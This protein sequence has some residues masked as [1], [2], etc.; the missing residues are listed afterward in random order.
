MLPEDVREWIQR[1]GLDSR[2]CRNDALDE[3]EVTGE[4]ETD[5]DFLPVRKILFQQLTSG[6]LAGSGERS[7]GSS[8]ETI[9]G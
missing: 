7:A 4:L 3:H 8:V 9:N 1:P 6:L 2:T 5:V